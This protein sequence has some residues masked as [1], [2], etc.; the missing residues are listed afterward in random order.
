MEDENISVQ[1]SMFVLEFP[2]DYKLRYKQF[3]YSDLPVKTSSKTNT[4]SWEI[5]NIKALEYEI[6]QP[7]ISEITTSV[8][9]APTVF[10]YGGYSGNMETWKQFGDFISKL[11]EGRDVLPEN[12]KQ[13]IHRLTDGVSSQDEKI[14]LLYDYLQKNT[15]YIS[16]QIGIGGFQPFDAKYVAARGYGD[17]KALSNYMKSILKE[18]GVNANYVLITAGEGKKGLWEDFPSPY[19]NHATMCIPGSKDTLWLE[20]TS[21]T[22]SAGFSGSFTGDRKA[23]MITN[24]GGVLINTPVYKSNDN[25]QLRKIIATIDESGKMRAEVNTHFTGIQ[26]ELQHALMHEANREQREKYLNEKLNLPTYVVERSDYKETK[27]RIPMIDEYLKISAPDYA[28]ITGKRLFIK[29][30]IFNKINTKLDTDKPRKF[31]VEYS[32]AFKEVDSISIT[33]PVGYAT[34]SLPSNASISNKFGK[35]SIAFKVN[36]NA[37]DMLRTYERQRS[38][39]PA[40]DYNDLAKFYQEMYNADRSRIVLVKKEQ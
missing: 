25:L 4:W 24:D 5:N 26:Q 11:N 19:F 1:Q 22:E 13:D 16:V 18:A 38:T 15:H 3:N 33:L 20:C 23:L 37:I 12:I 21:Q 2:L 30:N 31:P 9:V 8:Y 27:G 10:E 29:P 6:F 39:Y 35:Y 17:C 34:E 40:K 7:P 28:T 14:K 32:Y 36:G